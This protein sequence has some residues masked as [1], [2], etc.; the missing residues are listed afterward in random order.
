MLFIR[1]GKVP[2]SQLLRVFEAHGKADTVTPILLIIEEVRRLALKMNTKKAIQKMSR[3]SLSC[4]LMK[5]IK[6]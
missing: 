5:D 6:M 4:V 1:Q 3:F 2:A